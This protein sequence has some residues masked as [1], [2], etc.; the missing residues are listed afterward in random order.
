MTSAGTA[1]VNTKSSVSVSQILMQNHIGS[2]IFCRREHLIGAGLFRESLQAWQDW[3]MWVRLLRAYGQAININ[4]SSYIIDESHSFFRISN[5][6]ERDFRDTFLAFCSDNAPISLVQKAA[7][8]LSLCKYPQ[9]KVRPLD[10]IGIAPILLSFD[11][12]LE[13]VRGKILGAVKA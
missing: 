5:R 1:L 3:D 9:V 11:F 8:N 2:Q 6:P 13:K 12:L 10:I 7:I 4:S